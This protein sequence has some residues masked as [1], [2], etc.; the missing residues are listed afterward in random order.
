MAQGPELCFRSC[1]TGVTQCNTICLPLSDRPRHLSIKRAW[2]F[3]GVKPAWRSQAFS[4]PVGRLRPKVDAFCGL[5]RLSRLSGCP[6]APQH[7]RR[8]RDCHHRRFSG[9]TVSQ[10]RAC[11]SFLKT[12]IRELCCTTLNL[13]SVV[14]SA[15]SVRVLQA[16]AAKALITDSEQTGP[17]RD[18]IAAT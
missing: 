17:D 12:H 5:N 18:R 3:V 16:L 14:S 13:P 1:A 9:I 4:L 10:T 15:V 7:R 6:G 2:C 11:Q 8:R